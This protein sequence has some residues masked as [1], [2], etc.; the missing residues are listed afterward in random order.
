MPLLCLVASVALTG[1]GG[2]GGGVASSP[3]PVSRPETSS[4]INEGTL[5]ENSL[6]VYSSQF[7]PVAA[8]ASDTGGAEVYDP[9]T[10]SS[11]VK[12]FAK[13]N[14][15]DP[16]A[17]RG[18]SAYLIASSTF[19]IAQAARDLLAGIGVANSSYTFLD[20]AGKGV[21]NRSAYQK[22]SA[23]SIVN[24]LSN[25]LYTR[26]G[27]KLV[28]G[29]II[30][31]DDIKKHGWIVSDT[32]FDGNIDPLAGI[33]GRSW[34]VKHKADIE[35]G[36]RQA[37]ATGKVRLFYGLS[38]DGQSR[39]SSANGCKGFES[40]CLGTPYSLRVKNAQGR[41]MDVEGA[42]VS[43]YGFAAYVLA[44]ERMAADT[45]VAKV[46]E[47]ADACAHDLGE[48]GADADTGL[49]RLDVGCM[50][51]RIYAASVVVED[52]EKTPAVA[53]PVT[54]SVDPVPT[55]TVAVKPTVSLP[56]EKE[57]PEKVPPVTVAIKPA[58]TV[59]VAVKPTVSLPEEKEVPEEEPPV[60]I[61]VEPAP[62]V[63]VAVK[64][65]VSLP[66]EKEVPEEVPPVTVAVKPALA[67]TVISTTTLKKIQWRTAQ[68]YAK[69][70]VSLTVVNSRV[71]NAV[72]I[73]AA[74]FKGGHMPVGFVN[75]GKSRVYDAADIL[76]GY[77]KLGYYGME[78][79]LYLG[80]GRGSLL[81][82]HPLEESNYTVWKNNPYRVG[83]NYLEHQE[84]YDDT[85][86]NSIVYFSRIPFFLSGSNARTV[87]FSGNNQNIARVAKGLSINPK[88]MKDHGWIVSEAA[89]DIRNYSI[90][91]KD[92]I[93]NDD[94]EYEVVVFAPKKTDAVALSNIDWLQGEYKK[95]LE[96][97]YRQAAATGKL[98]LFYD[99]RIDKEGRVESFL[100]NWGST[101][102][103]GFENYCIGVPYRVIENSIEASYLWLDSSYLGVAHAFGIYLMAWERMPAQTH[104]S[105]VFAMGD[106]CTKD[107]GEKGPDAATGLGY[108][109]VGCIV[110]EV[111]QVNQNPAAATLSVAA[112]LPSSAAQ[113]SV[114]LSVSSEGDSEEALPVTVAVKPAPTVTVTV[115]VKPTPATTVVSTTSLKKIQWRTTQEYA[116]NFV[117]LTVVNSRA[118][119]AFVIFYYYMFDDSNRFIRTPVGFGQHGFSRHEDAK[120]VLE[121]DMRLVSHSEFLLRHTSSWEESNYT[122]WESESRMHSRSYGKNYQNS[123]N[124]TPENSIVYFPREAFFLSGS[125]ARTVFFADSDRD[126]AQAAEHIAIDPKTMQDHGWIV[127]AAAYDLRATLTIGNGIEKVALADSN[128]LQG[129]YKK[130]LEEGYRQAAATGKLRLFYDLKIDK[131]GRVESFLNNW[132]LNGCS[133]FESYC[134][135][136]PYRI[137][138]DKEWFYLDSSHLATAHAFGIY[139]M[140]WERMPA[141]THM[142]AVFAMGDRCTKDIGEKG[143]DAATGLGYL[144]VGC[145]VR[146]VYQVNLNPSA[147][148][149][150]VAVRLPSSSTAQASVTLSV[151]SE[152]GSQVQA[153]SASSDTD[154]NRQHFFDDFAQ[155]LFSDLGSLSLPGNTDASVE[156]GFPGD[157]FLGRYRPTNNLQPHY[158][159]YLPQ[160]GYALVGGK[161]GVMGIGD[162]E[163][164]IFTKIEGIDVSFSYRRSE[165]FFGG[166]GSGQFAFNKV[167]NTRLMMQRQLLPLSSEQG[168]LASGWVRQAR[169]T[170]GQGT[171]LD[172]LRGREYGASLR[173]D[174]QSTDGVSVSAT[175]WTS[176]FAGGEIGLAGERFAI[177]SSDWQW[178]VRMT[179]S[180]DF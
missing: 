151:S 15:A 70:F 103:K 29:L 148:T 175:A 154:P 100:N 159:S 47:L 127:S 114:A 141:E 76:G 40:Y 160:P 41:Y 143:P 108:L 57:V 60:T 39:H 161:L 63:T 56:E 71:R 69:S 23:N 50:A 3:D 132:G 72:V 13:A 75:R 128:W 153:Q 10:R 142:S 170:G 130:H 66:E 94:G 6:R 123:Y 11:L 30:S 28:G 20:T 111:Y 91:G 36:Y 172:E 45:S 136:V 109:D 126:L 156:A 59:T 169:V 149:L 73:Y 152:G 55:V 12:S 34:L 53:P 54:I 16:I 174:W 67:T 120:T 42:F 178:G 158:H 165:D 163:L 121:E 99:L 177:G 82:S 19:G 38:S 5:A 145:M 79:K 164:G 97:G 102:C 89:Y 49:G 176:R 155:E 115:A 138:R 87:F 33:T 179:G 37:V 80:K 25:P 144:D 51:S 26:R 84:L 46:F 92:R 31:P 131:E 35:H 116:K 64:P 150:S 61:S 133:G 1:C 93:K 139:L 90:I 162:G 113:A 137:A 171:L 119:N 48:A 18:S 134:I 8:Q 9:N 118:K 78:L 81:E 14:L 124:N 112:R 21:N 2:G 62:T 88:T 157:S 65:T 168:L 117:S 180:Y 173:Y 107:I 125:D 43:T 77:S 74:S 104:I 17:T 95:H 167:G 83:R 105:A 4:T 96:E 85:L 22:T 7:S 135:G 27:S 44:W 101:G 24:I 32:G 58:P 140:A 98:R 146:E 129:E 52:K 86:E 147:A 68:E 110:Q 166:S 106:R 122:V